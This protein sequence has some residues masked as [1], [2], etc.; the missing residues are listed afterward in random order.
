[1][2]NKLKNACSACDQDK[3][4]SADSQQCVC[5]QGT[6]LDSATQSCAPCPL[7]SIQ[8]ID[9]CYCP[10]TL[11]RDYTSNACRA[12]PAEATLQD[13][14]CACINSTL[15]FSQRDW[16]CNTCPGTLA[17]PRRGYERSSCRCTGTS[18]IFYKRNVTCYTCPTGTTADSDNDEC[19]CARDTGLDFDYTTETCACEPG[20][21]LNESGVCTRSTLNP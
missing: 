7:G 21:T 3:H 6:T 20:Y 8:E 4:I 19:D 10:T 12:C 15:F 9:L 1:V 11:A 2:W 13:N 17:P 16:T 18:E 5:N 14:K